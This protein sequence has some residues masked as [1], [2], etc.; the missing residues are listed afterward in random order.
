MFNKLCN[1]CAAAAATKYIVNTPFSK[2]HNLCPNKQIHE[3]CCQLLIH[4]FCP[5]GIPQ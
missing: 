1:A 4:S 3:M 2:H 5:H